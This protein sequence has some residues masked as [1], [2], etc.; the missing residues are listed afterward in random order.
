MCDF[1]MMEVEGSECAAL[2]KNN[3]ARKNERK[4]VVGEHTNKG[5]S[6]IAVG[7][8]KDHS[9]APVWIRL[10][11]RSSMDQEGTVH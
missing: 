8:I 11:V 7:A 2:V 4:R 5:S 3:V 9:G 6:F 10:V 1:S